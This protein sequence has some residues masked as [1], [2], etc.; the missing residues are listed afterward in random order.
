MSIC[1]IKTDQPIKLHLF[2]YTASR[3]LKTNVVGKMFLDID[4]CAEESDN[5]HDNATCYDTYG[6]FYC[7]CM[8]GFTGNGTHCEGLLI[9]YT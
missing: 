6:S 5:C 9:N 4:D 7:T 2:L 1:V 8:S 3:S